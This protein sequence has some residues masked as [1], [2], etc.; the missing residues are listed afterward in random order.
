MRRKQRHTATFTYGKLAVAFLLLACMVPVAVSGT[1]LVS[2][3]QESQTDASSIGS[4]PSSD[5]GNAIIMLGTASQEPNVDENCADT[6]VTDKPPP[7]E[8]IPTHEWQEVMDGQPVP[9]GLFIRFD[10]EKGK[11]WAKLNDGNDA[12]S[13]A[14]EQ[15]SIRVS[16]K[17]P[18]VVL[19]TNLDTEQQSELEVE[20][21]PETEG[22]ELNVNAPTEEDSS[23]QI[24]QA[25][26]SV[27]WG[28]DLDVQDTPP[29]V[30][31]ISGNLTE[32]LKQLLL[33]L[34]EPEPELVD[35]LQSHL[36]E[37]EMEELYRKVW[38]KR[39]KEI[40]AAFQ[41]IRDEAKLIKK[42]LGVIV[43]G[44]ADQIE[45][46]R[47]AGLEISRPDEVIQ[48]LV[49]L[50]YMVGDI[51]QASDFFHLGGLNV[52][53]DSLR[54]GRDNPADLDLLASSDTTA[55]DIRAKSAWVLGSAVKNQYK[56][57]QAVTDA[58]VLPD[59]VDLILSAFANG[60]QRAAS[61]GVYSLGSILRHNPPA[62]QQFVDILGPKQ[63]E[64]LLKQAFEL[65]NIPEHV[66]EGL[67]AATCD[68]LDRQGLR[69]AEKIV[70][71]VADLAENVVEES[72]PTHKALV[73]LLFGC[74]HGVRFFVRRCG[75]PKL[76]VH[77]LLQ[78]SVLEERSHSW[79]I[80]ALQLLQCVTGND[81]I[82]KALDAVDTLSQL[83]TTAN[84]VVHGRSIEGA[85][86]TAT[87]NT[88][89]IFRAAGIVVNQTA[90]NLQ[91]QIAQAESSDDT[92][93]LHQ[94]HEMAT[95]LVLKLDPN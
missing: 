21:E 91:L 51:D 19:E 54:F 49:D 26:P 73:R 65:D 14:S 80:I 77:C 32:S 78:V 23:I 46:T 7:P 93:Y 3:P 35:G 28:T 17:D 25:E 60:D 48:A 44:R 1:S 15:Y 29:P 13:A 88:D 11:K 85:T 94:L 92:E 16:E 24:S 59:V 75:C 37:A 87:S 57:Q 38:N 43:R 62:Q 76:T 4:V 68:N 31:E 64:E 71:L 8:F 45:A 22:Q 6:H 20:P 81:G 34:P 70:A 74:L 90:V 30:P 5:S 61:K 82:E 41:H 47:T 56:L 9:R 50:E 36:S 86:S 67:E 83:V 58:L 10:L 72:R 40:Q 79:F 55:F 2:V 89:A 39:Q 63:L 84:T 27:L 33:E 53:G 12:D 42:L 95:A 66:A 52:V 18:S 69:L